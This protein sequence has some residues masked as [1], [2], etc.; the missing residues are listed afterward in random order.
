[1]LFIAKSNLR[2]AL[3]GKNATLTFFMMKQRN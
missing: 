2:D 3:A 1:M